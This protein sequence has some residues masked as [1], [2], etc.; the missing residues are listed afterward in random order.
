[1]NLANAA[2]REAISR[3]MSS[4]RVRQGAPIEVTWYAFRTALKAGE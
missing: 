1:M 2:K 3:S 4:T